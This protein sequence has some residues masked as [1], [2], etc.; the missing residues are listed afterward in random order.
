MIKNIEKKFNQSQPNANY[1]FPFVYEIESDDEQ[2]YD[3]T[4]ADKVYV[5]ADQNK[6][7]RH[8]IGR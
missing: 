3:F 6:L 2:F 1:K 4:D 5:L 8:S 7:T